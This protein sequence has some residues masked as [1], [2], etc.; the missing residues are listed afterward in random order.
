M[1]QHPRKHFR[2]R[3][4]ILNCLRQT[5]VHPSA[6]WLFDALKSE[7]SD[8]SLATVYRNLSLF[9]QQ[10][11]IASLGTVAGVERFD[12]NTEPHVHFICTQC[13]S[14]LDLSDMEVPEALNNAASK[15]AGGKVAGCQLTFT[16]ICGHCLKKTN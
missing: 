16:G 5:T 2:K 9:M 1:E 14:I 6:E 12:G 15:S 3:D 10:G 7:H 4:A 11:T 13:A 8:I